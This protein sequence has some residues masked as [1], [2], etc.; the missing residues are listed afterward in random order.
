M[1]AISKEKLDAVTESNISSSSRLMWGI[2]LMV[3]NII[4]LSVSNVISTSIE[5]SIANSKI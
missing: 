2:L 3:A 4:V 1:I 5:D